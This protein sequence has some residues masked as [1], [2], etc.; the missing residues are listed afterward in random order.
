MPDRLS[1]T[2]S[3]LIAMAVSLLGE[4]HK[5]RQEMKCS[6]ADFLEYCAASK[7]PS[8]PELDRLIGLIVREQGSIIAKNRDLL[9]ALREKR[10][11]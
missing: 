3:R 1:N 7:E 10:N 9:A 4:P 6:E 8:W 5:V 11:K 2:T